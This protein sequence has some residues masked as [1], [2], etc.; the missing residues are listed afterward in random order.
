M[1]I[2]L[3]E[4]I[5]TKNH[6]GSY[7]AG[8][9]LIAGLKILYAFN[10]L[11]IKEDVFD[12]KSNIRRILKT[13]GAFVDDKKVKEVFECI[14]SY[15]S[16]CTFCKMKTKN[17][18]YAIVAS[19]LALLYR[20][21]KIL[22]EKNGLVIPEEIDIDVSEAFII[23]IIMDAE[24]GDDNI[25][26]VSAILNRST[27]RAIAFGEGKS[28]IM[29]NIRENILEALFSVLDDHYECRVEA[30][31]I[32]LE[33]LTVSVKKKDTAINNL[34][35]KKEKLSK[36]L[37][38]MSGKE[39]KVVTQI[40]EVDT[41]KS[42]YDEALAENFELEKKLIGLTERVSAIEE[43]V[44]GNKDIEEDIKILQELKEEQAATYDL[45]DYNIV[46]I[47]DKNRCKSDMFKIIDVTN[48][49]KTV[50]GCDGA[51]FVV[52]LTMYI[53]H[54]AYYGVKNYC[55]KHGIKIVHCDVRTTS[56][57]K[58]NNAIKQSVIE[59]LV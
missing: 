37:E 1:K 49:P 11:R 9:T 56:M 45:S 44:K 40:K 59:C 15:E 23:E 2:N 30:D 21:N 18:E 58:L 29:I 5:M 16:I 53:N 24:K 6:Y 4:F 31:K 36:Q 35:R 57:E 7:S 10:D 50:T 8:R 55:K 20:E 19:L 12:K 17:T 14:Y 32:K 46:V 33:E 43:A 22:L 42:L 28:L 52:F 38:Q 3:D 34:T 47:A 51:D 41:Y 48:Q 39:P 54:P 13:L 26:L 25:S 27:Q